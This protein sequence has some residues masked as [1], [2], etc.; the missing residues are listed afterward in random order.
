MA[1]RWQMLASYTV[2]SAKND[3]EVF[4]ADHFNRGEDFG[5]AEA[6][7]RH[8]LTLS[9]IVQLFAGLQVSSIMKYQ[10]ALSFDADKRQNDL[11]AALE[12]AGIETHDLRQTRP[13]MEEVFISLIEKQAQL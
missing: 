12:Q 11:V 9:G 8:R 6:D 7:R 2:A 10:S 5:Q 13:Q 1:Q 4:P 3:T